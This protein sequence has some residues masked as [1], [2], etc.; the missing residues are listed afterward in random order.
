[1]QQCLKER[2]MLERRSCV[3]PFYSQNITYSS[4]FAEECNVLQMLD[5]PSFQ[6]VVPQNTSYQRYALFIL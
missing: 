2:K 5:C 6:L 3:H 1:M 4:A